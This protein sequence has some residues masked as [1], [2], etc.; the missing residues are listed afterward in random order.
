MMRH[1]FTLFI[2]WVSVLSA[3]AQEQKD[4]PQTVGRLADEA[5]TA[6][7]DTIGVVGGMLTDGYIMPQRMADGGAYA[8]PDTLHLPPLGMHGEVLPM[9][10]RPLYYGGWGLWNTWGL[11]EGL[12]VSLGASV[13]AQFGKNARGGAGFAQN[14]SAM[15]AVPLSKRA[16]L[17][18]G[19]YF[20]NVMWGHGTYRDAGLSAVLGYKLNERWELYLYGQKSLAQRNAF[21]PLAVYDMGNIGD[22]IGTAVKYNVSPNVSVQVSVEQGWMPSQ[23]HAYFDQYNYPLQRP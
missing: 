6:Q 4:R 20:D 13:F 21:V 14:I 19:G 5:V 1:F 12:N 11:H 10:M 23:R 16:S 17:A 15:Y 18:V 2:L 8:A 22:R 9:V 3:S 7:H